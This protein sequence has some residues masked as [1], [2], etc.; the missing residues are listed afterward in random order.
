MFAVDTTGIAK[1]F[2]EVTAV[3]G[4][5]LQIEQGEVF[6]LL[7]PNG[8]GKTT[9]IRILACLISPT[10]GTASVSGFD[11]KTNPSS[12]RQSIGILTENPSLYEKLTAYENMDFF[13]EAYGLTD[14]AQRNARIDELLAF[15]NLTDRKNDKVSTFSKG[16]KQKL[17]IAKAIVH[18]PAILFLD[19]PTSNLD[20]ETSKEIRDL[21]V[22][23]SK[24]E[25]STILLSTHHLEDAERICTRVMIMNHGKSIAV[26]TPGEL[27]D[28]IV[29]MPFI[30]IVL[31]ELNEAIVE[32]AKSNPMTKGM[33]L[34]EEVQTM[35][36]QAEDAKAA[37]PE[38]VKSIVAAGG[39][40]LAVELQRPS[41][42]EAYLKLVKDDQK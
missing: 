20:P 38:L 28:K 35:M 36:V 7:G 29:G 15:F 32:A 30:K 31:T 8:A 42:E 19:E 3:D 22:N 12:V 37:T 27:R 21:I 25:K 4:L 2:K 1:K 24:A 13:A 5:S 16:M 40:I 18:K 39:M 6:G 17:A 34:N 11:V 23:L 33:L 10:E 41:L 26:G 14:K 9:T